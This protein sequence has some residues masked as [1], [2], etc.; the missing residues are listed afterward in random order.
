[1]IMKF[2]KPMLGTVQ[3]G[4]TYG[5]ANR[6]GQPEAG[7][8][9]EILTQA[10]NSGINV[11]DTAAAYGESE[12]VLGEVLTATN[13]HDR[14]DIITKTPP[15][16]PDISGSD[17]FDFIRSHLEES[18]RRLRRDKVA[19][20]LFHREDDIRHISRMQRL[21]DE[22]L[23]GGIGVSLDSTQYLR[24]AL[25]V[26]YVQLPCNLLDRRYDQFLEEAAQRNMAVFARSA[27]LQ[28]LLLMPENEI[29]VSL[30]AIVPYR[31][32][33]MEL[34]QENGYDFKA[35][36]I[37]FVLAWSAVHSVVF[38]VDTVEQLRGNLEAFK[39]KP[40]SQE[41][42]DKVLDSVPMLPESLIRPALW[43]R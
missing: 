14:F 10:A 41:L 30:S 23:V 39:V 42:F 7:R 24:Q 35:F 17:A 11:L 37:Q 22:G 15:L 4:L 6:T 40:L 25:D 16:P 5:I 1:M 32:K 33:L 29:P 38:G 27:F 13:L 20:L 31:R 19:V 12:S 9:A 26:N 2:S 18:L 3:F 8:V 34:A 36:C 21:L 28:G 43:A